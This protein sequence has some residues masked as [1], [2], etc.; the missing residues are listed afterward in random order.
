M[1]II[2]VVAG[3]TR[4]QTNENPSNAGDS[5]SDRTVSENGFVSFLKRFQAELEEDVRLAVSSTHDPPLLL[6]PRA[7]DDVLAP[8]LDEDE[9]SARP[10]VV[11]QAVEVEATLFS[12]ISGQIFEHSFKVHASTLRST[13]S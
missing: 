1:L 8:E 10:H 6:P 9:D 7:Q 4:L 12:T 13:R 2:G 11:R 3:L 5:D